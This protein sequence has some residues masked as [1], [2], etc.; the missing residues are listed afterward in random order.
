MDLCVILTIGNKLTFFSIYVIFVNMNNNI[1]A[2]MAL[3]E[4]ELTPLHYNFLSV[5]EPATLLPLPPAARGI[6]SRL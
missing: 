4:N 5:S 3:S 6:P 2:D 1:N